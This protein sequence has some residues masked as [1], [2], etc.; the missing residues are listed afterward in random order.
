MVRRQEAASHK[1]T[2]DHININH[3]ATFKEG[4][5]NLPELDNLVAKEIQKEYLRR[6]KQKQIVNIAQKEG[7]NPLNNISRTYYKRKC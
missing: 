7:N 6:A 3:K 1:E 4:T 5:L 2:A